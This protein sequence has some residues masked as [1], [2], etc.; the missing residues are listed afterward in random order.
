MDNKKQHYV[1]Q[2]YLRQFS[3][4]GKH[5]WQ[6]SAKLK[7]KTGLSISDVCTE[8]YFYD[9]STDNGLITSVSYPSFLALDLQYTINTQV[10]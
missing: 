3:Q 4:D 6:Y 2:F 10:V 5:I 1:P 7:K 9:L 8:N